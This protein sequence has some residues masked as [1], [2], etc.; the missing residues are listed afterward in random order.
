[1][2][3]DLGI[4]LF[5][6]PD[7]VPRGTVDLRSLD[8]PVG[9][10]PPAVRIERGGRVV[11][12][13]EESPTGVVA[14][15]ATPAVHSPSVHANQDALALEAS[16]L[17]VQ[18]SDPAPLGSRLRK[19][20]SSG[21][22]AIQAETAMPPRPTS[23]E[24]GASSRP[25][26]LPPDPAYETAQIS[27]GFASAL[28]AL[29]KVTLVLVGVTLA[30]ALPLLY[31]GDYLWS[32]PAATPL[33]ASSPAP[34]KHDLAPISTASESK[35]VEL[36]K[37]ETTPVA[38]SAVASVATASSSAVALG[39]TPEGSPKPE[40]KTVALADEPK[41][42]RI[43][44]AVQK[45]EPGD[46]PKVGADTGADSDIDIRKVESLRAEAVRLYRQGKYDEAIA[47]LDQLL[48]LSPRDSDALFRKAVA[49]DLKG[50]TKAAAAAYELAAMAAGPND[51]RAWNNLGLLRM[52]T[53]D[54]AGARAALE[55]GYGVN[56]HDA[57]LLTN[58]GILDRDKNPEAALARF[59]SALREDAR[60]A[61]ARYERASLL[62][63]TL[64]RADEGQKDL[65]QLAESDCPV[66]G[67]A[68]DALGVIAA[69]QRRYA[70]AEKLYRRAL[71]ADPGL[72]EARLH[73]GVALHQANA[74]EKAEAELRTYL[75]KHPKSADAWKTLGAA[76]VRLDRL[77][78]AKVAYEKALA[79]N[80][81]D[82]TTL[83]NYALCAERF[84]NF[85]FAIQEY[86]RVVQ[87]DANHW[88][89]LENLGRLYRRAGRDEKALDYFE[90]AL[91]IQPGEPDLHLHRANALAQLHRDS[92]ARD[93]LREFLR[94]APKGDKRIADAQ[95]ALDS[96]GELTP[97]DSGTP[98]TG[99]GR[100]F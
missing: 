92:D 24:A 76:L 87:L 49:M 37:A 96:T 52:R 19:R 31:W 35:P 81:K 94:L 5:V 29:V 79:E 77:P 73:L 36:G 97:S 61:Y 26:S 71:E 9:A 16:K 20:S 53:G 85:L 28:G 99:D 55:R 25:G 41:E 11:R 56:A 90:K 74:N 83:Y 45:I 21:A 43:D 6:E 18:A 84:G 42:S 67:K 2:S 44:S 23:A 47:K 93:E 78:E 51:A 65:E 80:D 15:P 95:H 10:Q 98:T 40:T 22:N 3:T 17:A 75:E 68:L 4:E 13:T 89:S 86:E 91:K 50:D 82:P 100:G 62:A 1:V 14:T 32:Q 70:D 69:G 66:R 58:L 46:G 48:A 39:V 88:K 54:L 12:L 33:A 72:D 8:A 57:N 30:V 63:L 27:G 60:N 59:D 7:V 34:K 64:R 38:P